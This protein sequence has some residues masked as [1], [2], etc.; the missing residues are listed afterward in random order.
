MTINTYPTTE[1]V[2][3]TSA[4]R[5]PDFNWDA[6]S[7]RDLWD[8]AVIIRCNSS[9]TLENVVGIVDHVDF[10]GRSP[11]VVYKDGTRARSTKTTKL[12]VARQYGRKAAWLEAS[13]LTA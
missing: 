3:S 1:H 12:T 8:G 13:D 9:A 7:L 10:T 4:P 6:V 5:T 11:V 2:S